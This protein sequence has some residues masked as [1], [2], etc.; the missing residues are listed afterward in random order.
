VVHEAAFADQSR[1]LRALMQG[2][3]SEG[4]AGQAK[5]EDVD[6]KTFVRFAQF[7]YMGDYS[8]PRMIVRSRPG[9]LRLWL[10]WKKEALLHGIFGSL[11]RKNISNQS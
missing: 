3:I 6:I 5:W 10:L 1:A 9:T 7:V 2:E 8:I 11:W 4:S